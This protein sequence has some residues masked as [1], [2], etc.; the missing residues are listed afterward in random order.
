MESFT[1][2][3]SNKKILKNDLGSNPNTTLT[4]GIYFDDQHYNKKPLK[5]ELVMTSGEQDVPMISDVYN[6][7]IFLKR[8]KRNL[9]ENWFH[10]M[11]MGD[12]MY[13]LKIFSFGV[14]LFFLCW[15]P[16]GCTT[17]E[18][19]QISVTGSTTILPFMTEVSGNY[20]QK[21]NAVIQISGGGSMKGIREL[22]DGKCSIA[23]S[24]SPIPAEML[25]HAASK[26]IQIKG[27]PFAEDVIVPIVHPTNLIHDLELTQLQKIYTGSIKF[28]NAVG[29]ESKPIE[30]VVRGESFGTGEVWKQVVMKSKGV[31]PGA[32]FQ[33][34]N[35]GVLAYVAE[36]P[37]GIGYISRALLNHEVKPLFV[38]GVAPNKENAKME[39]YPISRRLYLYVDNKNLPHHIKSLIVFI[40]NNK[41]QQIAKGCG[42][43]PLEPLK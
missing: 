24:S 41:G 10:E 36:H 20:S 42:F 2:P 3:A 12:R 19:S 14:L 27:F 37:E 30:V 28:W 38:S 8:L 16:S 22:I 35:S 23:M 7:G 31:K 1:N 39:K 26:G 21:M 13:H 40:L 11:K 15:M 5:Q 33:T 9:I 43:I 6:I 4:F 25:S 32:A 17:Q 29:G 34:S 18:P